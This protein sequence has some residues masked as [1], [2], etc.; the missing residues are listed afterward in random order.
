[1]LLIEVITIAIYLTASWFL[2]VWYKGN[3]EQI[4]CAEFVYVFFLGGLSYLY[5]RTG[6]WK[7]K[8]I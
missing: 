6:H 4:W 1:G 2:A 8:Q 3:V 5:L 7:Q